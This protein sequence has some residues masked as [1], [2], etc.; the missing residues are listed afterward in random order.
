MLKKQRAKIVVR[1]VYE[2]LGKR[3]RRCCQSILLFVLAQ[4]TNAKVFTDRS[5][6]DG[7][8]KEKR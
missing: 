1:M 7:A 4:E 3:A 2:S 5:V 6:G 8:G